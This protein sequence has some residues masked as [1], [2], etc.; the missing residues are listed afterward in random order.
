MKPARLLGRI[1]R[2]G[3]SN[4]RFSD[5]V[6]LVEALGFHEAGG[7]GSHRVFVH[8]EVTELINLQTERGH[9]KRYQVRQVAQLIQRYDL[10]LKEES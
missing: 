3:V 8:P 9:A 2:G 10:L 4:V 5:L 7:R 6:D 1:Q